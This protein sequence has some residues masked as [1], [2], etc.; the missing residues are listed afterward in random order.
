[1]NYIHAVSEFIFEDERPFLSCHASTL[2]LLPGGE[3]IAAWFGGTKEKAGDVAIWISHRGNDGWS[4]PIKVADQ[5]NVPHWNPVLFRRPDGILF[6]YYKVGNDIEHWETLVIQSADNGRSW[7]VPA[8]LVDGD[9]GGRGPVKNKP[10]V[11]HNGTIVAPAS[12]EPAWDAFVDLSSD[13]GATWTRSE[14]VPIDRSSL[15]GLKGQGIIQPTLWESEP[16]ILHMLLR[17]TEGVIYRSDSVDGG[18]KWRSAYPTEL[19]NNNSGIDLVKLGD[20]V[21]ALV[22]NP[23]QLEEGKHKGPRT[24]L[25]IRFSNDNGFTWENEMLLDQ[26]EKQYSYPAIIADGDDLY[27]TYTWKRE[28]IAFHKLTKWFGYDRP[29]Q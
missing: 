26:G 10:I 28:R 11:L 12:L 21:L 6:L 13:G 24:P 4:K 14:T 25:V 9:R 5:E 17:S 7:T 20:G 18:R 8:P 2:E 16:G 1:M 15:K 19:P 3:I 23:T 27:I 22:Y 29:I